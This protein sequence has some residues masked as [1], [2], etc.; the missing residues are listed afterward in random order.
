MLFSP[1][2]SC[3][4]ILFTIIYRHSLRVLAWFLELQCWYFQ[5]CS[6]TVDEK[7]LST[8]MILE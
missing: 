6:Q 7:H 2:P 1:L 5:A 8:T 3:L 4:Y